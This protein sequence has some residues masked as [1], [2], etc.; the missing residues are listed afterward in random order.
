MREKRKY[1]L[2][3][4]GCASVAVLLCTFACSQQA[5]AATLALRAKTNTKL[6]VGSGIG[7]IHGGVG[8]PIN[9]G[10][11]FRLSKRSKL[12]LGGDTGVTIGW[13]FSL[14]LLFSATYDISGDTKE[15]IRPY[16]GASVG[17]VF[18]FG[19]Y[20][21]YSSLARLSDYRYGVST[22]SVHMGILLRPGLAVHLSKSLD[23]N[24][25]S[26]FGAVGGM[27]FMAP[28]ANIVFHL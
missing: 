3:E 20:A 10:A 15:T 18:L 13:A 28:Q 24:V 5:S 26:P 11:R 6:Y 16:M 4:I 2:F 27:F 17:P 23:M 21:G 14:P 12:W 19:G 9:I 7:S 1:N 8:L 22:S 25:E